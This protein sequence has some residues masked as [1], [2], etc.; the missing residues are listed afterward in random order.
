MKKDLLWSSLSPP[1]PSNDPLSI[2]CVTKEDFSRLEVAEMDK[3]EVGLAL[4]SCREFQ[5][6]KPAKNGFLPPS[7]P[8]R[9]EWTVQGK[10]QKCYSHIQTAENGRFGPPKL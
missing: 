6:A 1:P 5:W 8:A 9:S 3:L 10:L 4:I 7:V 2:C